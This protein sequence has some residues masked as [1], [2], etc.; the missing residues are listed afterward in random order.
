MSKKI[1][2]LSF[3]NEQ[4][5]IIQSA[6]DLTKTSSWTITQITKEDAQNEGVIFED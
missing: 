4:E 5:Y 2:T 3:L 1:K 6:K